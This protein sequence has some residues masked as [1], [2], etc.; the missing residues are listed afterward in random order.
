MV[1]SKYICA[2]RS[3]NLK[4]W[5]GIKCLSHFVYFRNVT[6]VLGSVPLMLGCCVNRTVRELHQLWILK[7][8]RNKIKHSKFLSSWIDFSSSRNALCHAILFFLL[9]SLH[10]IEPIYLS[11]IHIY[12][13]VQKNEDTPEL[14]RDVLDRKRQK[15][16]RALRVIEISGINYQTYLL[17]G[18]PKM[19]AAVI[20]TKGGYNDKSKI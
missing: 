4:F 17:K 19:C 9:H 20:K 8:I 11:D 10:L 12:T 3:E 13:T 14:A 5:A 16:K 2:Q 18:M 7:C 15:C 6:Q 1:S